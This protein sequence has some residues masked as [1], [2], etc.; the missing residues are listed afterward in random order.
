MCDWK[1]GT[2]SREAQPGAPDS[3]PQADAPLDR[4]VEDVEHD[5]ALEGVR[6]GRVERVFELVRGGEDLGA[7]SDMTHIAR[8][9]INVE[10]QVT[11][12]ADSTHNE[13]TLD[14]EPKHCA[15]GDEPLDGD[16][17]RYDGGSRHGAD[18]EACVGSATKRISEDPAAQNG[19]SLVSVKGETVGL[20]GNA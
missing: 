15:G 16:V 14:H 10:S 4:R 20:T 5:L 11:G 19:T 13:Y 12:A 8:A 1:M 18:D 7:V 6:V 3:L 9:D 17:D 2:V